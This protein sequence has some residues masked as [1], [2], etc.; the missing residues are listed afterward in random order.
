MAFLVEDSQQG[1]GIGQL[2][3]EHLRPGGERGDPIPES[4]TYQFL[5][6]V[7]GTGAPESH[8]HVSQ[9]Q[10]RVLADIDMLTQIPNRRHFNDLAAEA[11][12]LAQRDIDS[13]RPNDGGWGGPD[14]AQ[15]LD[16]AKAW[17]TLAG[18]AGREAYIPINGSQKSKSMWMQAGK[19][20]GMIRAY[21][22]G[23]FGGYQEDTSDW[24]A[25][26]SWQDW[27]SLGAGAGQGDRRGAGLAPGDRTARLEAS[28]GRAP[29]RQRRVGRR[30][31]W[32]GGQPRLSS[33]PSCFD[34]HGHCCQAATTRGFFRFSR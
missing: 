16:D 26:K 30:A 7:L 11:L 34:R 6:R 15:M 22:D 29:A 23:G 24:M 4:E 31:Q 17:V 5:V 32:R 33:T 14:A 3:L 27:V 19:E 2:L 18:E 21:A 28:P 8:P 9:R 1:R 25:P 12:Q 13:S 20:L 10:L